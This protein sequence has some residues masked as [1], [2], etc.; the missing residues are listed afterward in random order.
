[1][2]ASMQDLNAHYLLGNW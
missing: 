2:Q 1:M